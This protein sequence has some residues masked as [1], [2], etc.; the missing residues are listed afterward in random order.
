MQ[1]T[2]L[3]QQQGL[4]II[5]LLVFLLMAGALG[6]FGLKVGPTYMENWTLKKMMGDLQSDKD[7]IGKN[8]ATIRNIVM[9]R[10]R[11]NGVYNLSPRNIKIKRRGVYNVVTLDYSVSKKLA[12]N[13]DVVMTFKETANVPTSP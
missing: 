13:M 9:K 1:L 3:K 6:F 11:V 5:G 8:Q 7:V 10:I 12:G 2:S 4:S